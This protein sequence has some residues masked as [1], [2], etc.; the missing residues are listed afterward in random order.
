MIEPNIFYKQNFREGLYNWFLKL[1]KLEFKRVENKAEGSTFIRVTVS[2]Q[3]PN[4]S[5]SVM[6]T[7]NLST[8]SPYFNK[9]SVINYLQYNSRFISANT[10]GQISKGEMEVGVMLCLRGSDYISNFRTEFQKLDSIRILVEFYFRPRDANGP[11]LKST[12][13]IGSGIIS[14]IADLPGVT[15]GNQNPICIDVEFYEHSINTLGYDNRFAP[16]GTVSVFQGD[17]STG[18]FSG[19]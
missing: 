8:L 11:L 7:D 18:Q 13:I 10:E 9:F 6:P 5:A 17:Y 3:L 2:R 1:S 14:K 15:A 19:S 16:M 12:E 4:M